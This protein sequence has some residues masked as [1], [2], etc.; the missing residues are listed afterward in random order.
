MEKQEG[1]AI[2]TSKG[3]TNRKRSILGPRGRRRLGR[4]ESYK[5]PG[6]ERKSYIGGQAKVQRDLKRE[7]FG[8]FPEGFLDN[9]NV[10]PDKKKRVRFVLPKTSDEKTD[11]TEW[12]V[13][14]VAS[15]K[16]DNNPTC[17]SPLNPFAQ[18]MPYGDGQPLP[19]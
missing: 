10:E 5:D 3:G 11:V 12:E 17:D 14:K 16:K 1:K 15:S 7:G 18:A 13:A 19:R 8:V 4:D 9:C 6:I 2:S